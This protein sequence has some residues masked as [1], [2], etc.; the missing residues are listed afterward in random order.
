MH[1]LEGLA[2]DVGAEILVVEPLGKP[3][4]DGLFEA[5][6]VEDRRIEERRQQRIARHGL[7][8]LLAHCAPYRIDRLQVRR[9]LR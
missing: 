3:V 2:D 4:D 5:L 8:S 6:L 7:A 1:R 9:V